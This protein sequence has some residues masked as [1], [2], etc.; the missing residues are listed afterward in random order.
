VAFPNIHA[1][2]FSHPGPYERNMGD[3]IVGLLRLFRGRVPDTESSARVFE[4]AMEPDLWSA[5]HGVF[6]EIRT[7]LLAADKAKDETRAAQYCFEELCCKAMYNATVPPDPFDPSSP[8][9]VAGAALQLAQAVGVPV[10]A[11]VAVLAPD[12]SD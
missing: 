9:F 3:C 11:V 7:R 6:D 4:L 5:G 8:Y 1:Y 12:A 10:A 2:P